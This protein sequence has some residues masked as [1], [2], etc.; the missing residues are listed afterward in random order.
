MQNSLHLQMHFKTSGAVIWIS[1][2]NGPLNHDIM[3]L[4]IKNIHIKMKNSD[5]MDFCVNKNKIKQTKCIF[6]EKITE[7]V[8]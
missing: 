8:I 2:Y 6:I 1:I 7:K 5:S 3:Y 4:I